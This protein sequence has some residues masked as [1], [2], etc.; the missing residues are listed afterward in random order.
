MCHCVRENKTACVATGATLLPRCRYLR[1]SSHL[2]TQW[3]QNQ[4]QETQRQ[5]ANKTRCTARS[6]RGAKLRGI[7]HMSLINLSGPMQADS[8][9]TTGLWLN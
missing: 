4:N 6:G 9:I 3:R 2:G 1:K 5:A 8:E 7:A